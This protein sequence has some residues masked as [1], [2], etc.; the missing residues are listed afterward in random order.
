MMRRGVA[1]AAVAIAI[2]LFAPAVDVLAQTA[3]EDSVANRARPDFEAIGIELDE[4]LGVLGLVGEETIERKSS[5]LSSF[6]VKPSFGITGVYES[7][8]FLAENGTV[9]D[10]RVE[11]NPGVTIQSDWGRH[12]FAVTATGTFGRYTEFDSEDFDDYQVQLSG[13]LEIHD[14][15]TLAVLAGIA[16]RHESRA[17]EDDPGQ[18]VAPVVS[19][20]NFTDITF[21][22]QADAL[23]ARFSFEFEHQD[24]RDSGPVDN[25][26]RDI[27]LIDMTLR[28]AYEFTPGTQIFVEPSADFR[29][30]DQKRDPQGNLQD[31]EIFGVLVGVTWDLTGVTFAEFGAGVSHQ[32]FANPLFQSQTNLDFSGKLIWNATDLM[33]ITSDLGRS[34]VESTTPGESGILT[35]TWSNGI[36]YEFL[37]NIILSAGIVLVETENQ[38]SRREDSDRNLRAGVEYLINENWSARL[39]LGHSHRSSTLDGESYDAFTADFG[40]VAKL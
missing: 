10:R 17:E 22:Y 30:F 13:T 26:P 28:L 6:V 36:D 23:L 27:S 40:L 7:N 35:T 32:Q 19:F 3:K 20:N 39:N 37:D 5:P 15:K 14:N 38:E 33:T 25:D 24:Y 34:T 4:L 9:S 18:G 8:L 2:A 11:Y 29:V 21:E 12:S 1:S 16:Q 31:N